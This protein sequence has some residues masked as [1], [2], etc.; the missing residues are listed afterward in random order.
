M[1][2]VFRDHVGTRGKGHENYPVCMRIAGRLHETVGLRG[3][4][5]EV[6]RIAD[7][8]VFPVLRRSGPREIALFDFDE[9]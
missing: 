6:L 8:G 9:R 4:K 3:K 7:A 1:N 2:L 5:P